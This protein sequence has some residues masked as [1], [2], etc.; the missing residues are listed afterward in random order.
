LSGE[1][2][3]LIVMKPS[4]YEGKQVIYTRMKEAWRYLRVGGRFFVLTHMRRGAPSL[5]KMM[6]EIYGNADIA[7]RGGGGI[8][9]VRA[10][11]SVAEPDGQPGG[12]TSNTSDTIEVAILGH[13]L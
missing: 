11:K 7:A 9:V 2:A 12:Q 8:R 5:I 4:S 1:T 10:I 3:D 6:G 13:S